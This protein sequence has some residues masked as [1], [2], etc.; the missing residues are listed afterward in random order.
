[1][2][3]GGDAMKRDDDATHDEGD[4]HGEAMNGG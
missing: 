1:M 2:E 4:D 3:G